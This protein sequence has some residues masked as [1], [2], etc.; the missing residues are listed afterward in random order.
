MSTY[1]LGKNRML[2]WDDFLIDKIDSAEVRMHKP[3]KREK[4][5]TFDKSWEGNV[6][7]YLSLMRLGDTYRLY[8]RAQNITLNPDGSYSSSKGCYCVAES[9]DLKR[10]ERLPIPIIPIIIPSTILSPMTCIERH[11]P[12]PNTS[13]EIIPKV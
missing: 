3:V 11:I 1:N 12:V 4:A 2:C 13:A 9:K 6:C 10:F 5:I 8:Y 7:T